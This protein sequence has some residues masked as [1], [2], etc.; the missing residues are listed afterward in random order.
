ML[1]KFSILLALFLLVT[2]VYAQDD[3]NM[4]LTWRVDGL[5]RTYVLH[6]PDDLTDPVPLVIALHGRT[7]DGASMARLT[8]FSDLSDEAGFMVAYPDGLDG[9]W[10]F[11]RTIRGY[12]M[13]QDDTAFLVAL[14]DHIA[15]TN[16]IDRSR[17]YLVGFSNGGF[18]TQRV[19]CEHPLPFAAFASVAAA[20][21]GGMPEVCPET[22]A[23]PVPILLMNGTADSNIP[24]DGTA[25]TRGDQTIYITY[26]VAQTVGY[27]AEFNG[28]QP[29]VD[30]KEITPLGE[31]PETEVRVLTF[32]CPADTAVVLYGITGGGHNWAGQEQDDPLQYGYVNRDIDASVEIWQFFSQYQR[33]MP[34]A[35]DTPSSTG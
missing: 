21:F 35:T 10:N 9:E 14:V 30:T 34:A 31:S 22:G 8:H 6:V 13:E 11:V 26:P 12:D 16:P 17:V 4:S 3:A 7:G 20:G 32:T 24:W 5:D 27:W 25:V 33:P 28:C 15:E 18:M 2:P 23:V 29:E 1:R 19:A